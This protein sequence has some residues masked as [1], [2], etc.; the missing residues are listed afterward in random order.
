MA[1]GLPASVAAGESASF[2][3]AHRRG[4]PLGRCPGFGPAQSVDRG[5]RLALIQR[6]PLLTGPGT[7]WHYSSPGYLLAGHIVEQA[8]G[9]PYAEFLTSRS[10]SRWGWPQPAWAA[11]PRARWLRV[12]TEMASR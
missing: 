1:S 12:A 3:G 7:R 5:Q 8:S 4:P 2:A 10:W 6:A 11:F 9:Q